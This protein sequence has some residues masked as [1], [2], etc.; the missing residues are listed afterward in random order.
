M[1]TKRKK[2]LVHTCCAACASHVFSDLKND[3]YEVIAYFYNPQVHGQAEYK[4]RLKDVT[5]LC[6]ADEVE[7]LVPEYNVKEFF[8]PLMPFQDAGS[9]KYIS[10]K[11]RYRRKRCQSCISLLLGCSANQAKKRRIKNFTST[12]LCSPYKD[13]NEIWNQGVETGQQLGIEF[14]YK[15]FRKGYWKGRNYAR[16]HN[17]HSPRYCGCSESLEEGRLE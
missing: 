4:R 15:D 17:F 16:N 3:G 7:L 6:V 8:A 1:A 14:Y 2:I 11:N 13:H 9:I 12:L 5:A 10:D